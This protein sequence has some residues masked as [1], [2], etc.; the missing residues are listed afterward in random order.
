MPTA[1][2]LFASHL[3]EYFIET[4]SYFGDGIAEAISA[5]FPN[6]ISIELA[7]KYFDHCIERFADQPHVKIIKGDSFKKLPHILKDIVSPITFWLDGHHSAGDTGLG[8]YWAPLIHE[9]KAIGP[10][11]Y[12]RPYYLN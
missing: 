5:G 2:T 1:K 3:N 4:G 9:L 7:D 12:C 11:F 6:I 10:T 8:E